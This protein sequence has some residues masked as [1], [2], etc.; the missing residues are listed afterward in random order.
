MPCIHSDIAFEVQ[1]IKEK[2]LMLSA[3]TSQLIGSQFSSFN[4]ILFFCFLSTFTSCTAKRCCR[5]I[6]VLSPFQSFINN[7]AHV[8]T[9]GKWKVALAFALWHVKRSYLCQK[10]SLIHFICCQFLT[11]W[12]S[13]SST[14]I[15]D[16]DFLR[17]RKV[18]LQV[19][20][21]WQTDFSSSF[22]CE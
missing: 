2:P 5:E 12:H 20:F 11:H 9:C 6:T 16:V 8:H 13:I 19:S 4:W 17:V 14:L 15:I 18:C 10:V 3:P 1:A 7:E 22:F 21:D